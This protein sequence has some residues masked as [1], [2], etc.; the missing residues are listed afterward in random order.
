MNLLKCHM[1]KNDIQLC[2]LTSGQRCIPNLIICSL[3]LILSK[4]II[5][6]IQIGSHFMFNM[7]NLNIRTHS[8]YILVFSVRKNS[9]LPLFLE[10]AKTENQVVCSCLVLQ[11]YESQVTQY[12]SILWILQENLFYKANIYTINIT[13]TKNDF[14]N[15]PV[16]KLI[17]FPLLLFRKA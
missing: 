7:M 8:V 9:G 3:C 16:F 6:D 15:H 4:I 14:L 5:R 11:E 13:I 2:L 1:V 10:I 17:G 12:G